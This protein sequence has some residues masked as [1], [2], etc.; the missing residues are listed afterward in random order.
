MRIASEG[1]AS[2]LAA[3]TSVVG[4]AFVGSDSIKGE[5]KRV[6]LLSLI[7]Y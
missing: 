2:V 7:N 5:K 3:S 1:F 6:A 4:A